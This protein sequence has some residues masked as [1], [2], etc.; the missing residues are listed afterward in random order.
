M[1]GKQED[2]ED[3]KAAVLQDPRD[4]AKAE[5]LESYVPRGD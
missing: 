1:S 4:M 3:A 2:V 5:L